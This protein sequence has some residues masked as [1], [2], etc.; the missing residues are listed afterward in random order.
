M[1]GRPG[2]G[3]AAEYYLRYIGRVAGDD[4]LGV[5]DEQAARV[6]AFLRGIAEDT[7]LHRYAEG[8][9]TL[10]EVLAHVNDCERVFTGRAWWFARGQQGAL[11][12]FDP[13]SCAANGRANDLAWA[14]HVEEFEAVRA[15]TLAFF[16]GLPAEAWTRTGTASGNPFSVRALAFITAGHLEHHLA[17]VREKYL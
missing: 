1:K 14:R 6:P 5:L 7:S 3:E 17:L 10:R 11:S 13:D 16:R 9:W 4:V 12:S 2:E 15:S 8:K